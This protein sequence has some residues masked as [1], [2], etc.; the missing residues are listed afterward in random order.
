MF[1]ILNNYKYQGSFDFGPLDN[2]KKQC[3]APPD[4]CGIYI[5]YA[6]L[7]DRETVIYIGSSGHI[8]D[9][10]A[11]Q[12]KGGLGRRI[13]GKQQNTPRGKLWPEK[14]RE[15]SI[16]RLKVY[17]CNT[18]EDNPLLVEYCLLLEFV[19]QNKRFPLWNNELKLNRILKNEFEEFV[20][21]YNIESLK[22]NNGKQLRF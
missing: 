12:R 6:C 20:R 4:C 14:M 15:M 10:K 21:K 1:E 9:G 2:L 3:N 11:M 16:D 19:I 5:V 22:V 13:V 8:K 17:W 18:E 7:A